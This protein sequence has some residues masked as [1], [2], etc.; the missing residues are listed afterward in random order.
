MKDF[1]EGSLAKFLKNFLEGYLKH[2]LPKYPKQP[3]EKFLNMMGRPK[4]NITFNAGIP[5]IFNK[6]IQ[7][8]FSGRIS[9]KKILS[10]PY[11]CFGRS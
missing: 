11:G 2:S 3:L 5:G 4:K 10:N 6:E 1:L 7:R 8:R 9:R